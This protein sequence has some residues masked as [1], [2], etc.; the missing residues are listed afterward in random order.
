MWA[1][2]PYLSNIKWF[3]QLVC[4]SNMLITHCYT[5]HPGSVH[6]QRVFRLSDVANFVEDA[7]KFPMDS[8]LL[9][10]AAY[11]LH[12]HLLVPF[13][14]NGHLTE[15]QNKYNRHLST[16]RVTIERCIGL[17]KARM[18]S[19]LHC[20]PMVRVDQMPQY[21]IACCV[22]H[23]ICLLRGDDI[24][25][26]VIPGDPQGNAR[27]IDQFGRNNAVVAKRNIIMNALR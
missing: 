8:H 4:D 20:L 2:D 14:D 17:L 3:L 1:K 22:I 6:D 19:L 15:L 7:E 10:D 16:A 18:R 23:N 27:N 12:E 21:I 5:G 13:R 11:E 26:V 25:M 9:G 24:R